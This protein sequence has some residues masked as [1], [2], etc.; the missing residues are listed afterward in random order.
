[1]NAPSTIRYR[2]KLTDVRPDDVERDD[3]TR[4]TRLPVDHSVDPLVVRAIDYRGYVAK[5]GGRFMFWEIDG[6]P[7][8][9]TKMAS[10]FAA[11]DKKLEGETQ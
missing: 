6:L 4:Y 11:I 7:G 5:Q 2:G 3:D 9:H 10:V 8:R 1:M